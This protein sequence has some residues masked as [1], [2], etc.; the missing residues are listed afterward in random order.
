MSGWLRE[1]VVLPTTIITA[2]TA[3]LLFL[4]ILFSRFYRGAIAQLNRSDGIHPPQR[5]WSL[6][7]DWNAG[8]PKLRWATGLLSAALLPV[9]LAQ[10][11]LGIELLYLVL[12]ASFVLIELTMMEEAVAT[13]RN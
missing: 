8:D 6:L 7:H 1:N 2:A 3:T 12:A 9:A 13:A 10:A 4:R 11:W 5:G